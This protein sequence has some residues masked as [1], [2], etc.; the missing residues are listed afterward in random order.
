MKGSRLA[1]P[2][3]RFPSSDHTRRATTTECRHRPVWL[4]RSPWRP[5]HH[6]GTG[7][8]EFS[9]E[10]ESLCSRF[11]CRELHRVEASNAEDCYAGNLGRNDREFLRQKANAG[12]EDGNG[13]DEVQ[14]TVIRTTKL[15]RTIYSL[16]NNDQK[17]VEGLPPKHKQV[18]ARV[19]FCYYVPL[20]RAMPHLPVNEDPGSSLIRFSLVRNAFGGQV[21]GSTAR[22]RR[23]TL[24]SGS[25]LKSIK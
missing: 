17:C 24:G 25:P 9:F 3:R 23:R 20:P 22:L 19:F 8:L 15:R 5:R 2:T 6:Q 18:T 10:P 1:V 14:G 12:S 21:I 7:P 16:R 4:S 11:S 13:G